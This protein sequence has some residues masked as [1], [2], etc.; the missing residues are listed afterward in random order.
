MEKEDLAMNY[1]NM[2]EVKLQFTD[3]DNPEKKLSFKFSDMKG[4]D[5]LSK[6]LSKRNNSADPCPRVLEANTG[7]SNMLIKLENVDQSSEVTPSTPSTHSLEGVEKEVVLPFD[8]SDEPVEKKLKLKFGICPLCKEEIDSE[9]GS[10]SLT[11]RGLASLLEV[12]GKRTDTSFHFYKGQRVHQ[13]CRQYY[14]NPDRNKKKPPPEKKKTGR[15]VDRATMRAFEQV[16]NYLEE[17]RNHQL[18]VK[19]LVQHMGT[20][21]QNSTHEPYSVPWMKKKLVDRFAGKLNIL[22]GDVLRFEDVECDADGAASSEEPA[23]QTNQIPSEL[24]CD[25]KT[26]CSTMK[27]NCR[28]FGGKCSED[29]RN[30]APACCQNFNL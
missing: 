20:L 1:I 2:S 26:G 5:T 6:A 22:E 21:L 19:D 12:K 4:L 28:K 25:C 24:T 13:L 16:L 17:H 9:Y 29:C 11:E 18:T 10:S 15:P 27:C 23:K 30:C 7:S 8:E 14:I 3:K